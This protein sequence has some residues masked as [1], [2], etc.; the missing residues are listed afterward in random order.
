MLWRNTEKYINF[1]VSISKELDNGKTITYKF[2]SSESEENLDV[3]TLPVSADI[4]T[5]A[6]QFLKPE[7]LSSQN[8]WFCFS[9]SAHSEST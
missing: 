6:N 8:K 4:E 3:L 5:S 2:S 1:S 9:Y 7:I